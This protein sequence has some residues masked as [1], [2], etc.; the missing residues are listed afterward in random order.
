MAGCP[1]LSV[2]RNAKRTDMQPRGFA[3]ANE[4]LERGINASVYRWQPSA[5]EHADLG[6]L[7]AGGK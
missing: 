5:P 7:L 1:N 4:L 2:Q 3:L 6:W